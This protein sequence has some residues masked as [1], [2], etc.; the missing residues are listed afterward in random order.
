MIFNYG[1]KRGLLGEGT[2]KENEATWIK[3][4]EPSGQRKQL[5]K[6]PGA[7]VCLVC[8]ARLKCGWRE[9]VESAV[10]GNKVRKQTQ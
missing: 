10:R 7:E 9:T 4:Q 8:N 3:Y 5:C 1:A 6:G 2:L